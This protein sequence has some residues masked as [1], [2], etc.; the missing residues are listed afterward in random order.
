MKNRYLLT[1]LG[2]LVSF[3]SF[4]AHAQKFSFELDT[5]VQV[6][7]QGRI[8]PNAWAG[9]LNAPQFSKMHLN[10]DQV[11]DLVIFDR[12]SRKIST[13]LAQ[14]T[15]NGSYTWRH[16]PL[17]EAYFPELES[18]MLLRDFDGDGRKDLF[19]HTPSGIKVYQNVAAPSGFRWQLLFDPLYTEGFSGQVNMQ[20][21]STDVPGID[22]VDGDGDLDLV[23]FDIAG[24][25]AEYH[26]NMSMERTGKAGLTFKKVGFCW[27]NFIK[28]Q[29]GDACFNMNCETGEGDCPAV[30]NN[31]GGRP[32]HAGNSILLW[33]YN[34]DGVKDFF[35]SYIEDSHVAYMPNAGTREKARF[36][37]ADYL[38]PSIK[39]ID[40]GVFPATFLEDVTF[41]GKPDL[42]AAPN[43]YSNDQLKA[44]DFRRT[45]WLYES[46]GSGLIFRKENFL[47]EDMVDL[48]ENTTTALADLDGDGDAD[49][50]VGYA[51]FRSGQTYR[52]GIA[53]FR[54]VGTPQQAKFQLETDDYLGLATQLQNRQNQLV[55]N[56]NI[57][58]SDVTGD[59]IPDLG[60]MA[61]TPAGSIVRYIPNR[62]G[63]TGAF[64]LNPDELTALPLPNDLY[65]GSVPL[66]IDVN[67][68]GRIDLLIGTYYGGIQ[69]Y[70]NTGTSTQPTYQ[71]ET[72]SYGGQTDDFTNRGFSLIAAD[73]NG[74]ERLDLLTAYDNGSL[75]VF[76]DFL[77]QTT[78][79][80][81]SNSVQSP[82]N[83]VTSLKIGGVPSLAV[84]DLNQDGLPDIVAGTNTGG[85][86]L[87]LNRSE[88][89]PPSP[90]TG[91]E[92]VRVGPN[93]TDRYVTIQTTAEAEVHLYSLLGQWLG[94]ARSNGTN[95]YELDFRGL[96]TGVY[97]VQIQTASSGKITR[98]IILR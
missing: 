72:K 14:P 2:L 13:F 22:D 54:N 89:L 16:A 46:T 67:R 59:G 50:L 83:A 20:V 52:G 84:A 6:T 77:N 15:G 98:K 82:V 41:D 76:H 69:Y 26:Q 43:V 18:W 3:L 96:P 63:K 37:Q 73:V 95:R 85:L 80:A 71:L 79:S 51:G 66:Y 57:F 68:D 78:L 10:Q 47:Q 81:D 42:L 56:V 87:L 97:L 90:D 36:T 4:E 64:Q 88:K 49:L 12:T 60:F 48:G 24:D 9:G 38:F 39:P 61:Q 40:M 27:G 7:V 34:G 70:R 31:P 19:A 55:T 35:Y 44:N 53:L 92:T 74:D 93:P 91:T 29:Y 5:A 1:G 25:F 86:R 33:D 11:E 23:I 75:K 30:Q 62:G 65:A 58:V 94:K 28:R 17:Y 45:A 32:L 8:L 21:P